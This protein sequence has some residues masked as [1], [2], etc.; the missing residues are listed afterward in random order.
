[1]CVANRVSWVWAG[2]NSGNRD[3]VMGRNSGNRDPMMGRNT[4]LDSEHI[5]KE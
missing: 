1:M 2:R 3:P 5:K 4:R